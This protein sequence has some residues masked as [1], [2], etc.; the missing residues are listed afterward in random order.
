MDER[1][2]REH[3]LE[4][5][6]YPTAEVASRRSQAV[7]LFSPLRPVPSPVL[8]FASCAVSSAVLSSP[9]LPSPLL[10]PVLPC[11]PSPSP[12][13]PR[14]VTFPC[15]AS[16]STARPFSGSPRTAWCACIVVCRVGGW[17]VS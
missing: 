9:H 3:K 15:P 6:T 14:T 10:P 12:P 1:S 8:S 2:R 7:H 16:A 11:L 5:C 4:E 17:L 13:P